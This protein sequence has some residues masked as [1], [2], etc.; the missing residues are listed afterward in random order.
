MIREVIV[1]TVLFFTLAAGG[2]AQESTPQRNTAKPSTSSLGPHPAATS[3]E[4]ASRVGLRSQPSFWDDSLKMIRDGG[5]DIGA[6]LA[7]RRRL[8]VEASLTNRYFWFCITSYAANV[9]LMY[10]FYASRVSEERKIWKATEVMT[11]LWNW[12]LYA[13]WTARNAIDK[14]NHHIDRCHASTAN[15]QSPSDTET[16]ERN[17]ADL[18]RLQKERDVLQ[19]ELAATKTELAERDRAIADLSSRVSAI[20]TSVTG[21]SDPNLMAQLMDTVNTLSTRNQHLEQQLVTAQSKLE[22]IARDA[23]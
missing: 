10:L 13:D 9:L 15:K 4:P 14:H 5:W 17:K 11:D 22:Q 18:T 21:G 6:W 12:G 8:L 16:S 1:S 3:A 2:G 20:S 23:H 7:Y 19:T